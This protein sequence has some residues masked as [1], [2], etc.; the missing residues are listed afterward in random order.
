MAS[1]LARFALIGAGS[2][3]GLVA[4]ILVAGWLAGPGVVERY[5]RKDIAAGPGVLRL[6]NPQFRWNLD[7]TADSLSWRSPSLDADAAGLRISANLWRSLFRFSPSVDLDVAEADLRIKPVEDTV[8][9]PKGPPTFKPF[10]L[11]ASVKARVGTLSA[12]TDTADIGR[13]TEVTLEGRGK[14]GARLT[15]GEASLAALGALKPSLALDVDWSGAEEAEAALHLRMDPPSATTRAAPPAPS[16]SRAGPSGRVEDDGSPADKSPADNLRRAD[17][18]PGPAI[19]RGQ[20][21]SKTGQDEVRL[22]VKARM[23]DLRRGHLTL[24]TRLG[25]VSK[26]AALLG[27]SP[28]V[29][30]AG[31]WDG[32][33]KSDFDLVAGLKASL[34]LDGRF[35]GLA[36]KDLP[37]ALG[38]QD[39]A[40]RF[41]FHDSAGSFKV[42]S[43]ADE[44]STAPRPEGSGRED[45]R[46]EGRLRALSRDSLA[47]PSWLAR[48]MEVTLSGKV[49]GI[50]VEAAG[51]TVPA[52][53]TVSRARYA[54]GRAALEARTG[55]GSTVSADLTEGRK[56]WNGRFSL[57]VA[58]GEAWLVAFLDTNVAFRRFTATGTLRDGTVRAV[59]E[60]LYMEAYGVQAD[61]LVAVHR[62]GKAGYVLESGRLARR[63]TSWDLEGKVE[64]AKKGRPM[65][66]RI[67]GGG[68]GSLDF[69][70]ANPDAMEASARNLAPDRLPYKGLDSFAVYSPRV[71]ADFRW[72]RKAK[73]GSLGLEATG[74]YRADAVRLKAE[75]E[76]D[77]ERLEVS[78]L[79]A[80]IRGS[81]AKAAGAVKLKGRQFYDLKGLGFRD[82]EHVSL[83]AARFDLAEAMRAALPEPPLLSGTLQGRFEYSPEAGF[84]GSY[85]VD[86]LQPAATADLFHVRELRLRGSGDTLRILAV[87]VSPKEPLLNDSVSLFLSGALEPTQIVGFEAKVGRTLTAGFRGEM[88]SFKDIRG[89]LRVDGDVQLPE[90]SGTLRAVRLRAFLETPFKDAAAKV[91]V[92]A[93][94]LSG[95]YVVAGVDTQAFSAPLVL[96]GGRLSIPSLS[97]KGRS[98]SSVGGRVEYSLTGVR[99]LSARLAGTG[100]SVQA[101]SDKVLLRDLRVEVK[102]DSSDLSAD[103]W[104]GSGAFE[105]SNGPLR[106][107]GEFSRVEASYKTPLGKV[108]VPKSRGAG[109]S[110]QLAPARLRVRAVLDTSHVRYRLRSF[111]NWKGV[112][113]RGPE[114]RQA[115]AGRPLEVDMALETAGRGNHLETDVIRFSYV[116]NIAMKGR[117]PYALIQGRINGTGGELGTKRIAY[118]IRRLEIKW[119]NAPVEEGGISVEGVRRVLKSC[120]KNETDSCDVITRLVGELS[121]PQFTY[122]SD[123]RGAA[124]GTFGG[125]VEPMALLYSVRRGCYASEL[126]GGGS[127]MTAQEQ[128]LAL[129]EPFASDQLTRYAGKLTG[130]WIQRADVSGLGALAQ[131]STQE[132]KA[133]AIEVLSKEFWRLQMRLKAGYQPQDLQEADPWAYAVGVEWRPPLFRLVDDPKWKRRIKNNVVV[134]AKV[135]RDPSKPTEVAEN[136]LQ[137]RLGLNYNYDWWGYWWNKEGKGA[138]PKPAS[139]PAPASSPAPVPTARDIQP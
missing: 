85:R 130:N 73:A 5:L 53:V 116:G 48:H 99:R 12:S 33:V 105:H 55:D 107:M 4:L 20:S 93:D 54:P 82:V 65:A 109:A 112:F 131:D 31:G 29:A 56:G 3:A 101:G 61:S 1:R 133:I 62:Y 132:R 127:G 104:V 100:L 43:R 80:G 135:E 7:L 87:T 138:R 36:G 137:K 64:I 95:E 128:A 24:Q 70:M 102:A 40:V 115:R 75:A 47:N 51:K 76:W 92:R 123:C 10:D 16:A 122:D 26:Y 103:A 88:G 97:L 19:V 118:D 18:K 49:G 63:G 2:L 52:E 57:G 72:D 94:T 121:N 129:L 125:G 84:K 106:A 46:L 81:G 90:K 21:R 110:S 38:P 30:G 44:S 14:R 22:R 34:T 120:E 60:A 6:S 50:P 98:G 28:W 8:E 111:A 134:E 67:D 35:G 91:K 17:G 32:T 139:A 13:L 59:T 23:D 89:V 9:E 71:T 114:R 83:E 58:P 15:I 41:S 69:R 78:S 74:R 119:L 113:K 27:P 11:P 39:V 77:A 25:A 108:P 96:E 45:F 79:E 37:V 117:L 126:A 66:F 124:Q 86:S 136:T 42:S 68:A